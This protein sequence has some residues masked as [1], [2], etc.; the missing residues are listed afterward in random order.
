MIAEVLV[1]VA[2]PVIA[3]VLEI[4]EELVTAEVSVI[5]EVLVIVVAR[6]SAIALRT[7]AVDRLAAAV[8]AIGLAIAASAAAAVQVDLEIA[9]VVLAEAPEVLMEPVLGQAVAA[10]H[11]AWVHE[12][13]VV[14][15]A[16]R[17]AEVAVV[18]AVAVA[19]VAAA[20]AVV[21]DGSDRNEGRRRIMKTKLFSKLVAVLSTVAFVVL[22]LPSVLHTSAQTAASISNQKTFAT[23]QE[24]VDQLVAAAEKFDE[25]ALTEILGPSSWDI[26]HTGE[27]ARDKEVVTEF[28]AK[29]RAKTHIS[30]QPAKNPRRAFLSIGEDDWPFPVPIVKTG[31]KWAFDVNAG[32]QEILYRRIGSNELTAIQICRGYVE[33][34]HEYASTKHE[35]SA[36]NQYAQKI[37]ST[38]GKQDG[39]AWQ[40]PDGTWGGPIGENV[41]KAVNR[42]YETK[43]SPYHGYYFKILT[44]QGP[45]A[46]LGQLDFV[47]KGAMIGGF[48]LIAAPAQYRLTGVKTFMVSHDGVVYEKDLGP[49]TLEL[50]KAIDRFNPDKSWTPVLD[51]DDQ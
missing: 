20:A 38:P 36:V 5:A 28:A 25:T 29:A 21:D 19:V 40:N 6:A 31:T 17:V 1:I 2:A 3:V 43:Q 49:N 22:P 4:A 32:R 24:A 12:V 41:A 39:L 42:G 8:A 16:A 30:Q 51:D 18:V 48:A 50:A 35:G 15:A 45:A 34:Q 13:A 26:I 33:A 10:V 7:E 27:A 23:P 14:L 46:P 47:V 11:R 44:G 9:V 37:I